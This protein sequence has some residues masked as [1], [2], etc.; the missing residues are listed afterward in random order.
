MAQDILITPGSG[1][2]QI[3]FRGSGTYDTPIE[4]NVLSSYQSASN[5]GSALLFEGTEGQL[6]AIT[7]N[8]SSGVIFSVAGA[9]GLP[10]IE[11]DASGDV[12]LIEYGR[13]VGV[14]TGTPAYQLDV[15][16]TGRFSNGIIFGDGTTQTTAAGGGGGSSPTGTASGVAFFGD[17]NN[18]TTDSNFYWDTGNQRLRLSAGAGTDGAALVFGDDYRISK[19]NVR[20]LFKVGGSDFAAGILQDGSAGRI[21]VDAGGY[22]SWT[23]SV[24]T[25]HGSPTLKLYRDVADT[26]AL[27]RGSNAQEFRIYHS[28][29]T[30]NYERLSIKATGYNYEI[31]PQVNGGTAGSVVITNDT[32]SKEILVVKGAAAQ[33]ANL[34]EWQDSAGSAYSFIDQTG[35]L[36]LGTGSTT[37]NYNLVVTTGDVYIRDSLYVGEERNVGGGSNT[38]LVELTSYSSSKIVFN[39]HGGWSKYEISNAINQDLNFTCLSSNNGKGFFFNPKSGGYTSF[40]RNVGFMSN[41]DSTRSSALTSVNESP[42]RCHDLSWEF[43]QTTNGSYYRPCFLFTKNGDFHASGDITATGNI[44][45]LY[46]TVTSASG[47]FNTGEIE[48]LT[49]DNGTASALNVSGTTLMA[50][51]GVILDVQTTGGTTLFAVE[52][53]TETTLVVNSQDGQTSH[54]FE[55]RDAFGLTAASIDVSGN[56]SGNHL[57]FGDGT[58][59]TTAATASGP[60]AVVSDTGTAITMVCNTHA[61]KYLRTTANSAVTI[62]FPSGLGCD[63]NSEFTFEQAGSGQITVTGAAGVT[64]NTSS[65]TKTFTQFSVIS[66]KQ[67]ATDTY[68]LFGDTASF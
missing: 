67:V 7:D 41:Y 16:G 30:S 10:F 44:N 49:V 27:R 55:V 31:S 12:R 50:G 38:A 14:G 22:Y 47:V 19:G 56:I 64:I 4:L 13:Y 6:F 54:P 40:R 43:R 52:D 62:T 58:T 46:G 63:A 29:D 37:Y 68:T 60:P 1:E 61:D 53:T 11:A 28:G 17:D 5:S 8:L 9:A 42:S 51:T 35:A 2:P 23:D 66:M 3:L 33:S 21:S 24:G 39:A 32:S 18:L 34:Q 36:H 45:A 65:T 15:F 48:K 20:F 26:L 59:Q 57:S 25:P